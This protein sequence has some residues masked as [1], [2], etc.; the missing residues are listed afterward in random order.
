MTLKSSS[1]TNMKNC[2]LYFTGGYNSVNEKNIAHHD[3]TGV[4]CLNL[5]LLWCNKSPL[6]YNWFKNMQHFQFYGM[7]LLIGTPAS[8]SWRK[9]LM[10]SYLP[11]K[12]EQPCR[13][14][15]R[16]VATPAQSHCYFCWGRLPWQHWSVKR[17]GIGFTQRSGL[18]A[19]DFLTS[20]FNNNILISV[21]NIL[22]P[23]K[24]QRWGLIV[25]KQR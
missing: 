14:S 22:L 18:S 6:R 8:Y 9:A 13:H 5:F 2:F 21:F 4:R 1:I 12:L 24:P 10:S 20:T 23:Y 25:D 11:E 7:Q 16:N 17:E 15:S 19:K 3:Y